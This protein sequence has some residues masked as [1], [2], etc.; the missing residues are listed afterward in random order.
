MCFWT[1]EANRESSSIRQLRRPRNQWGHQWSTRWAICRCS[2]WATEVEAYIQQYWCQWGCRIWRRVRS[3]L[4]SFSSLSF[5]MCIFIHLLQC[6]LFMSYPYV[7]LIR[8]AFSVISFGDGNDGWWRNALFINERVLSFFYEKKEYKNG[9]TAS[10][11]SLLICLLRSAFYCLVWE[12]IVTLDPHLTNYD[13][14]FW[15]LFIRNQLIVI[16]SLFGILCISRTGFVQNTLQI[17]YGPRMLFSASPRL[18]WS[19]PKK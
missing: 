10:V 12:D 7:C 15:W 13:L 4:S 1:E 9:L 8:K 2:F 14:V 18:A 5:T 19:S 3:D 16:R 11:F 17:Q 6:L